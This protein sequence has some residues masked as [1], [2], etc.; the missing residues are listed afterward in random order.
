MNNL[1]MKNMFN[2]SINLYSFIYEVYIKYFLNYNFSCR[3]YV[4]PSFQIH[5]L[6]KKKCYKILISQLFEE[7]NSSSKSYVCFF[8]TETINVHIK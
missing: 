6:K 4:E 7:T 5:N 1:W 8:D 2:F 3:K